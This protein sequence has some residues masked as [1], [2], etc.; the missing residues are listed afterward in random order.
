[1]SASDPARRYDPYIQLA[2]AGLAATAA[3][4][5][6]YRNERAVAG[7]PDNDKPAAIGPRGHA[8]LAVQHAR[9]AENGRGRE[10]VSPLQIPWKGWKDILW[11]TYDE[12]QNDR[13][14]A[15]AAGVVFYSLLA[16]FPAVTAG[17][18]L[19]GLFADMR[20][21]ADHLSL[22]A[23]IV[24][25]GAIEIIGDQIARVVSRGNATLTFG[26]VAGVGFALW[27]ANA[28]M[29]AMFDALNIIN[30]EQ[31]KRSFVRLNAV[32]L[33]FTFCAIGLALLL[34]SGVIGVPLVLA[35]FGVGSGSETVLAFGRWPAMLAVVLLAFSVLYRFGPSRR[36]AKWRWL[37]VGGVGAALVWLAVSSGFSYYVANF[38]S[39]NATYGSL[40]AV[41]G[42]MMWMWIS[43]IVVLAGAELNSEIEHQTAQDS[44]VGRSP[45]PLGARGAVMADTVG[46]AKA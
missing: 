36:D 11:R 25:G 18:S 20:T 35:R 32:S 34:V 37:S 23:N 6:A 28:G 10:A 44:T 40:G 17:V 38:G 45:K 4:A 1:M 13:L 3:F 19:Y 31:E 46:E 29:K 14:L 21:L 9:A 27:S 16:L 42:M 43:T 15:L 24:P 26:F 33:F 7:K 8:P 39:Y 30:D 5:V 12:I 2:V 41:I 22:V